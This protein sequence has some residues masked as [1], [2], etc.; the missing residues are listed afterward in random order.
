VV[1]G[2]KIIRHDIGTDHHHRVGGVAANP[3]VD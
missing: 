2:G 1:V 3:T